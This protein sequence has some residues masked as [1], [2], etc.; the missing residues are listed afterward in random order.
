M[1]DFASEAAELL[2][3]AFPI[4][5][6][7]VSQTT[8]DP[9]NAIASAILE[10]GSHTI[11]LTNSADFLRS[12]PTQSSTPAH[13]TS[14]STSKE[15][16]P[17]P[18]PLAQPSSP[19]WESST[20]KSTQPV[21]SSHQSFFSV[22]REEHSSGTRNHELGPTSTDIT[23]TLTNWA[24]TATTT[25]APIA[26]TLNRTKY[27][28]SLP[29]RTKVAIA[30]AS[31]ILAVSLLTLA[32]AWTLRHRKNTM[33][34]W[35]TKRRNHSADYSGLFKARYSLRPPYSG[36]YET[37]G[38][39][40]YESSGLPLYEL[41]DTRGEAKHELLGSL[42]ARPS[43]PLSVRRKTSPETMRDW[44]GPHRI[45]KVRG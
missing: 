26:S 2:R 39:Q 15:S 24:V 36:H 19:A 10:L 28:S 40:I 43:Y 12:L 20:S 17:M 9:H 16:L 18:R 5:S 4:P 8:S 13:T 41:G 42:F 37:D 3:S 32:I 34:K 14:P 25:A 27:S 1:G 44:K 31:S 22:S 33:H 21:S 23:T 38:S 11:V 6:S 45:Y 7:E 35:R 29:L 30:A